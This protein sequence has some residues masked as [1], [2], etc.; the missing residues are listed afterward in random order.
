MRVE[1]RLPDGGTVDLVT[2]GAGALFGALAAMDGG[3]RA[4][5]CVAKGGVQ[6]AVLP[7]LEFQALMEGRTE[8]ALR[9]QVGVLRDLFKD[10]RATNLRLAELAAL[11]DQELSLVQVSDL[12]GSLG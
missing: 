8:V 6:V 5:S 7:R 4:A 2:V 10:L 9:F 12:L 1:R 11:E 3:E